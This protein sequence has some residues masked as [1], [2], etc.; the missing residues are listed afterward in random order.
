MELENIFEESPSTAGVLITGEPGSGKSALMSQLICSPFSSLLIHENTI[1]YHLCEYSEKGKR[2]GARFVRN[3]VDQIAVKLP[4]Y[5]EHVKNN[6]RLRVELNTR[7]HKDPTSCFFTAIVGP[8]RKLEQPNTLRFI[9][10]DALDEC[11]ESDSMTSEI[12]NIL[13]S[14]ILAF[15]K[16][17]K[18]IL[19]SRNLTSVTSRIPQVV[20]RMPLYAADERNVHD[21][22]FY[23]SRFMSQNSHFMDKL[24]I[25]MDY[26]SRTK[27]IKIFM[28]EIITQAEGNFLFVKTTL[29]YMNDTGG[30][31]DFHSLPTSL[32]D[33]YNIFF[34][35]QFSTAGFAPFKFLFEVLLAAYSPLQSQHVEEILKSEYEADDY[36]KLTEQVSC[37]LRFGQD[38]TIRIYHQSFA[39]WLTN[40]SPFLSINKTRGHLHIVSF[41][42]RHMRERYADV[43]FGELTELFIHILSGGELNTQETAINLFNIT[44]MREAKTNQSILHY[45]ATK[46]SNYLPVFDFFL[47]KFKTVDVLD[48]NNK[49]PAFYAASE[50]NVRSLQSCIDNGANVASFLE[51]FSELDPVSA[52]VA[53]TGIE[54]FSLIHLAAAKGYEEIAELL[55]QNKMSFL[56]FGKRYPTPLHLAASNGHLEVVRLFYDY[57]ETFDL[58]TLHHAA[59]RNH[60]PIVNYLLSTVG[61]RDR[62]VPCQPEHFSEMSHKKLTIQESHRFFCETAL[63]AAVSRGLIDIVELL[64]N[65]GKESL[66]CKHHSGKTV[67][68][69][70]VESNN[71]KMVDLL[72][73]FGANIT[74]ACGRKMSKDSVNQ[75]CSAYDMH[76][77][78]F[79]YTVYCVN[80]S[81]RCGYTAIHISAKYGFW[82]IAEKMLSGRIE[83]A[84]DVEDC[85]NDSA[86]HVAIKHDHVDFF[87]NACMSLEKVGQIN[88]SKIAKLA[89]IYCSVNVAN[90]FL[91]H[92]I[93]DDETI[94]DILKQH[95]NLSPWNELTKIHN[96][97]CMN[98]FTDRSLSEKE[99]KEKELERRL[100]MIK[101]LLETHQ[102]KSSILSKTDGLNWTL[103]HHAAISGFDDAVKYLVER[104]ADVLSKDENGDTPLMNALNFLLY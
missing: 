22:R 13:K 98:A 66:E 60:F 100:N 49:T 44:E 67:L 32:Y 4:K 54:E 24:L 57:N 17:L 36:I 8:L 102:H 72:F 48:A 15:P 9:I 81:C 12:L 47:Q 75:I 55:L 28:D 35:R 86:S 27:G 91:H 101:L 84:I 3:L 46:P 62:C 79:L 37:F 2:D 16:W 19:T 58:I 6:E 7:C 70:A 39:E 88:Y 93:D 69:D 59:A 61:L 42:M 65:F 20:K 68:M 73:T 53:N 11:F 43:T 50:G 30:K 89:I 64:L 87:T 25:A 52:V 10:I 104:G 26:S 41:L 23:V 71:T 90:G 5:S 63:H 78:D 51:G 96:S 1:G 21:V 77:K 56:D 95:V 103:L 82:N 33:L 18:I 92:I 99:A 74:A 97:A 83:E 14:K 31:V 94:W 85:N 29:Q 80:D 45:L 76:K 40:Q 38:G 34:D